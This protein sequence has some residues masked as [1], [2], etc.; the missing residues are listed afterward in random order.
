MGYNV[1]IIGYD[2]VINMTAMNETGNDVV[3]SDV[4]DS[5]PYSPKVRLL[6]ADLSWIL[7]FFVGLYGYS[8]SG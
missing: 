1:P 7:S 4:Y 6:L 5:T 2:L 3:F 8:H